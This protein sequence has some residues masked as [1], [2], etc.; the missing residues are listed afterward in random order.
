MRTMKGEREANRIGRRVRDVIADG[1]RLD[2][3][4]ELSNRSIVV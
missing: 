1:D 2:L 3:G 4:L